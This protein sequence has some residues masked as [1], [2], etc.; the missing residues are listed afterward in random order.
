M[1]T[2]LAVTTVLLLIISSTHIIRY[3]ADAAS[4][5]IST[6]VVLTLAINRIPR[7][8]ELLLPLG[9]F[10][11]VLLAHGRFYLESE[12][13]VMRACGLSY[14][15]LLLYTMGPAL[16]ISIAVAFVAL[17]LT[18]AGMY[19]VK[20]IIAEQ[21]DRTELEMLI[22]GTFQTQK[23]GNQVTY[24]REINESGELVDVFVSGM[25]RNRNPYF[26]VAS[27][28]E[29][30]FIENQ[31]RFLVLK[32]GYRYEGDAGVVE[33][34]EMGFSEYGLKLPESR[35]A[36]QVTDVDAV[37]TSELL[38]S[39]RPDYV[40]RLHWRLS[41]PV[42]ALVVAANS[43][44]RDLSDL[45][46]LAFRRSFGSGTGRLR[47]DSYLDRSSCSAFIGIKFCGF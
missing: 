14:R 19:E 5:E 46:R 13:I 30:R 27:T 4:G 25:D 26:L 2:T 8:L 45:C 36:A 28:A 37:P 7:F 43:L 6:S 39:T 18:P 33:F 21:R 1:V 41:L 40:S 32:E 31:G 20:R 17:Y 23:R 16:L 38:G 15:R 10:L 47:S 42:L 29:Q 24:A 34:N 3:L 12:M 35:L 44:N 11:G 9:L 22:P